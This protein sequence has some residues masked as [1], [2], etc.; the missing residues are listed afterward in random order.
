MLLFGGVFV[1]DVL[2]VAGIW[3]KQVPVREMVG[4]RIWSA[5]ILDKK[6]EMDIGVEVG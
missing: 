5:G 1:A 2:V 4:L 6:L 3:L